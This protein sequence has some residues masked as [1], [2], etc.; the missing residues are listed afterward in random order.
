MIV[1]FA[2]KKRL[3]EFSGLQGKPFPSQESPRR[4]KILPRGQEL[5]R[6]YV[7]DWG[8]VTPCRFMRQ[9]PS[10]IHIIVTSAV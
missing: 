1:Y 4:I 8:D 5:P 6:S 7:K 2:A 9:T 10:P 3:P